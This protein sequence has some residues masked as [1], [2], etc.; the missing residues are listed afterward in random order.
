M[1]VVS[2]LPLLLTVCLSFLQIW[3][4]VFVRVILVLNSTVNRGTDLSD[5]APGTGEQGDGFP[6]KLSQNMT[7]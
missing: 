1:S 6:K 7:S 2:G 4:K 3:L 5:K